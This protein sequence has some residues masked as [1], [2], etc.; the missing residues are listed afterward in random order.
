VGKWYFFVA[1]DVR[2]AFAWAKTKGQ[3]EQ[4]LYVFFTN[5]G[6]T[7]RFQLSKGGYLYVDEFKS[8]I[9]DYQNETGS[10]LALVIDTCYSGALLQKLIYPNRVIISSTGE[11][12]AYFDR[13]NKQSFS[14]FFAKGLLQGRSFWEA[15]EYASQK[16]GQYVKSLSI[17]Q[18]QIPQWYDGSDDGQ[19]LRDIFIN[20]SFAAGDITLTVEAQTVSTSLSVGQSL[21]LTAKVTLAQGSVKRVWAV[22]K[23]PKVSLVLDSNGTPI[24]AFPHLNLFRTEGEEIWA[25]AWDDAVYNGVYEVTFYAEDDQGNIS[26]SDSVTVDVVGGVDAPETSSVKIEL[27]KERYQRGESFQAQLTEELGWGYDLYAAVLLPDGHFF[28]LRDTN[29]LAGINK[30]KK[31]V[32]Q[33]IP[34][35]PVTLFEL[36]LPENLPTG[37]YCLYGILSPENEVVLET[38]DLWVWTEQCFDIF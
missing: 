4:P 29:K 11:G 25:T 20:G 36:S 21:P 19:W 5:H 32:G 33:R 28:A 22:I 31:W 38:L 10:E 12:L 23:P 18:D 3:L 7:D 6:G 35:S 16:Q 9:D 14:R 8:I 15:F 27:A 30:A 37:R 24:L 1:H 34:H 17:G 26:A 13:T 2:Q